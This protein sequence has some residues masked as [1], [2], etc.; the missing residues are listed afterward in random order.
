MRTITAHG[1]KTASARRNSVPMAPVFTSALPAVYEAGGISLAWLASE[2]ADNNV[3]AYELERTASADG[4]SWGS[5]SEVDSNITNLSYI[6]SPAIARSEYVRYRCARKGR[7]WPSQ[8]IFGICIGSSQPGTG[9]LDHQLACRWKNDLQSASAPADYTWG[10]SGWASHGTDCR[11][12]H[13]KRKYPLSCEPPID[14]T[15]SDKRRCGAGNGF[16]N[17][18]GYAGRA[19]RTG[20][21]VRLLCGAVLD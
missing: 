13:I 15:Q 2:D 8:R 9:K 7:L 11:R 20:H 19:E 17:R 5:Y 4:N 1:W 18:S 3:V 6:D 10:G 12:I 21:M 14:L 16:H